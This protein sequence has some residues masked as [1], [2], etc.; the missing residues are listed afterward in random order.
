VRERAKVTCEAM[1]VE[2]R[3]GTRA[4]RPSAP[5][6]RRMRLRRL[7]QR[8]GCTAEGPTRVF[9][10]DEEGRYGRK[11]GG[12][13]G[14]EAVGENRFNPRASTTAL[15]SAE[16]LKMDEPQSHDA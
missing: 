11:K 7:V 15:Q 16:T 4:V 8:R 6:E 9:E 10:S 5:R 14:I 13:A 1:K 3:M 2:W 12:G